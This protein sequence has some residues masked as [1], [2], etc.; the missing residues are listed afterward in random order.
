MQGWQI[1]LHSVRMVTRNLDVALRVS[2]VP[3]LVQAV[4]QVV[5]QSRFAAMISGF[6]TG[7]SSTS[8]ASLVLLMLFMVAVTILTS[9]WIAVA[10]HRFILLN[11]RPQG[12]IPGWNT[13]RFMGYLG[14]SVL[15]A[16][17]IGLVIA[18]VG[19]AI[20]G[21][22]T[23]LGASGLLAGS[24]AL[25]LAVA[26]IL[27]YRLC[28]ILPAVALDQPITLREAWDATRGTGGTI[29][30]LILLMIAAS[31]II[32][33]PTLVSGDPFSV[34]SLVYSLV[35]G[36]IFLMIGLSAL[37]TFYGVYVEG[38]SID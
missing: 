25:I 2:L 20:A 30:V 7:Q 9:V 19:G 16:L 6:D 32:Q 37:T 24:S 4:V 35:V 11:E 3:Y 12:W 28:P 1:F 29:F 8:Q 18:F 27:F 31:L 14:R 21:F 22:L 33:I 5:Y 23:G 36:W 38:R 26:A 10:W 34:V 17:L 13:G 15:L